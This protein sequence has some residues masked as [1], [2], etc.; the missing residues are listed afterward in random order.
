[1]ENRFSLL[2]VWLGQSKMLWDIICPHSTGWD[3]V[4]L[5]AR[6]LRGRVC[7]LLVPPSLHIIKWKVLLEISGKWIIELSKTTH[8][9]HII[10]KKFVKKSELCSAP[11]EKKNICPNKYKKSWNSHQGK[12]HKSGTIMYISMSYTFEVKT[13]GQLIWKANC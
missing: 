6:I 10:P 2:I 3:R 4:I 1:M 7:P 5:Y 8:M 12:K 9:R 13:K 11:I